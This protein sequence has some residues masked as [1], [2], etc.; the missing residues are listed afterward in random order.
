MGE[1]GELFNFVVA[2]KRI[3]FMEAECLLSSSSHHISSRLMQK[4]RVVLHV[5]VGSAHLQHVLKGLKLVL[6]AIGEVREFLLVK[7]SLLS[8]RLKHLLLLREV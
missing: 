2:I 7:R 1:Y 8:F 5:R 4:C 6:S 3:V